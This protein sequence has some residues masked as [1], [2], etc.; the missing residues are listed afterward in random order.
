[1][2]V[3]HC[4][5]TSINTTN[6]GIITLFLTFSICFFCASTVESSSSFFVVIVFRVSGAAREY[7]KT[8]CKTN[9]CKFHICQPPGQSGQLTVIVLCFLDCLLAGS[10]LVWLSLFRLS[11][12]RYC[13]LL[14][15]EILNWISIGIVVVIHIRIENR[16]SKFVIEFHMWGGG[17][18]EINET[19]FKWANVWSDCPPPPIEEVDKCGS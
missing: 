2:N 1:M 9:C 8:N 13:L 16:R 19:P 7:N 11:S 14:A 6:T 18:Y 12:L 3:I 5:T 10:G 4:I 17:R 15:S